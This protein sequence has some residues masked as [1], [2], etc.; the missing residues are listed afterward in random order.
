MK[1][2]LKDDYFIYI[3]DDQDLPPKVG[4]KVTLKLTLLFNVNVLFNNIP[5]NKMI[6]MNLHRTNSD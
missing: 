6:Q 4:F 1:Q 5:Q 2:F 3:M